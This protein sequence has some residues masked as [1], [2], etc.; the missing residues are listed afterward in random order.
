LNSKLSTS[1][2][3]FQIIKNFIQEKNLVNLT[4][5]LGSFVLPLLM[6]LALLI[7]EM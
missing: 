3:T 4:L 1:K 2:Q 5:T 6:D 7:E